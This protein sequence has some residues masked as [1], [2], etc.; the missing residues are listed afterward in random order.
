MLKTLQTW[1]ALTMPKTLELNQ[2]YD[3]TTLSCPLGRTDRAI[4]NYPSVTTVINAFE[5]KKM[6]PRNEARRA[7]NL[8]D[9]GDEL[10]GTLINTVNLFKDASEDA[11]ELREHLAQANRAMEKLNSILREREAESEK[12]KTAEDSTVK[13]KD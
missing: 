6:I 8:L 10:I 7:L 1:K 2:K 3:R 12:A 9:H 13:G 11:F 4:E 5:A